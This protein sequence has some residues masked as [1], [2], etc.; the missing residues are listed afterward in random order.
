MTLTQ[1]NTRIQWLVSFPIN[2]LNTLFQKDFYS[3][4]LQPN[5][6]ISDFVY[7]NLAGDVFVDFRPYQDMDSYNDRY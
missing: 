5:Q 6:R 2:R 3:S 7:S 4:Y 1:F